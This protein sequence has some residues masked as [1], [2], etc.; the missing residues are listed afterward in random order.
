[1]MRL[2]ADQDIVAFMDCP[3]GLQCTVLMV[4]PEKLAA[5]AGLRQLL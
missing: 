4:Y 3:H 5:D 2:G 1:M